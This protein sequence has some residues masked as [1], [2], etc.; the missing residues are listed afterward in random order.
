MENFDVIFE[1]DDLSARRKYSPTVNFMR[2]IPTVT[3]GIFDEVE[4]IFD[5]KDIKVAYPNAGTVKFINIEDSDRVKLVI[6]DEDDNE[7]GIKYYA[8][9]EL[10]G[11]VKYDVIYDIDKEWRY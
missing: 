7:L 9:N 2:S 6:Y 1:P 5:L 3:C 10:P 8:K 11:S 4:K